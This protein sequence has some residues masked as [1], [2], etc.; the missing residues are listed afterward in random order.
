VPTSVSSHLFRASEGCIVRNLS[1]AFT[2]LVILLLAA[3]TSSCTKVSTQINHARGGNPWTLP[4]VFR[5][6]FIEE[7]SELNPL[8]DTTLGSVDLSM[9]WNSWLFR[10][11]D[12]DEWLPDLATQFPT[13]QNGGISADGLEITYHLRKGVRWHDG[14][15]FTADDVIYSWQQVMNPNNNIPSRIPYD[16][17]TRIDKQDAFTIVVHLRKPYAPFVAEFFTPEVG[18]VIL[19]KHL[20]SQYSDLNRVA[21]NNHPVGTGPFKVDAYEKGNMI[22]LVANPDYFRGAPK[23]K[24]ID[25]HF[26]PDT[27]TIVTQLRTH[28][29]DAWFNAVTEEL[30][31]LQTLSG[32]RLYVTPVNSFWLMFFNTEKPALRDKAVRQAL[33]YGVDLESVRKKVYHGVHVLATTDQPDFIWAHNANTKRYDYDPQRAENMLDADGWKRG[34]DGYRYKNGQRLTIELVN[35]PYGS[36]SDNVMITQDWQRIGVDATIKIVASPVLFASYGAGGTLARGNFDVAFTGW[37]NGADPDDSELWMCAQIPP[38]GFNYSHFCSP[39]LDAQERIALT[40]YDR[41]TRKAAYDKIQAILAEEEP[42][43]M[44]FY[45][46]RLGVANSDLKGYKPAHASTLFWNPWEWQI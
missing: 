27:N 36:G 31:T 41:R 4:G 16:N 11:N 21:F 29:L 38:V 23:I 17:I 6:A 19:P 45:V 9:F 10:Y 7:P 3:L 5:I 12:R 24:E 46:H 15:P 18:G 40:S 30:P 20:L 1:L 39:E 25:V 35:D 44:V 43:I 2:A 34:S 14:A 26:I 42:A 22:R 28:E 33:A 37:N 13:Y 32:V 8:I